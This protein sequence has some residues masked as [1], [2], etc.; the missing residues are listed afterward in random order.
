MA[1]VSTCPR[2]ARQRDRHGLVPGRLKA[3]KQIAKEVGLDLRG[4][5]VDLDSGFDSRGSEVHLRC[6]HD[7]EHRRSPRNRKTTK[8]R[9]KRLFNEAIHALRL[10]VERTF[11]WEDRF[12]GLLLRLEHIQ[13]RHYGMK[14]MAYS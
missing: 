3:L 1:R 6:R 8:R 14:M 9:H 11:A 13:Q 2:R 7:P 12:R 4:A 10:R 5:Y